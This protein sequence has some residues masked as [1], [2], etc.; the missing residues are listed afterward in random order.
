MPTKAETPDVLAE[1]KI[2]PARKL[3][4]EPRVG[5]SPAAVPVVSDSAEVHRGKRVRDGLPCFYMTGEN[6]SFALPHA[7]VG[8]IVASGQLAPAEVVALWST[9]QRAAALKLL[10]APA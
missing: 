8:A 7:A 5:T 10:Q 4:Y 1:F 2:S 9:A 6:A 3:Q